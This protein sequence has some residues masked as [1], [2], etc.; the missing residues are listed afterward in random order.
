MIQKHFS[1]AEVELS[2]KKNIFLDYN[3]LDTTI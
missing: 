3:V 2:L 1:L